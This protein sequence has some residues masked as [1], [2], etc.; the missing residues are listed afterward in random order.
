MILDNKYFK[1]KNSPI[2]V[3]FSFLLLGFFVFVVSPVSLVARVFF[4]LI[5][6]RAVIKTA[7]SV[8]ALLFT[9]EPFS[10]V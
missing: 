2:L 9:F 3:S 7:T 8:Q 10:T 1:I 5:T 6:E 4:F